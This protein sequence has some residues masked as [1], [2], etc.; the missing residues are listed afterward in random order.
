MTSYTDKDVEQGEHSTIT[1]G[2]KSLYSHYGHHCG[3]SLRRWESRGSS[4]KKA[5][6]VGAWP[7]KPS[8]TK[9]GKNTH[10]SITNDEN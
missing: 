10:N 2:S 8:I 6:S 4:P 7:Y 1:G 9:K 5:T 3:G